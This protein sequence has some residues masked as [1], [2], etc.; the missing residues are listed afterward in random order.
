MDPPRLPLQAT[1]RSQ[2]PGAALATDGSKKPKSTVPAEQLEDFK[3][4]I[5]G[6]DMTKTGLIEV[7]K[8]QFP[9]IPKEAIKNTVGLVAERVGDKQDDKRWVLL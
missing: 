6:S 1:N 7:L 5:E 8:K 9:K 3:R 4:A 2:A